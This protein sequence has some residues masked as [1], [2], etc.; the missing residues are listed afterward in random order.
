MTGV[1]LI[2]RAGELTRHARPAPS[3]WERLTTVVQRAAADVEHRRRSERR[4]QRAR[5]LAV[6]GVLLGAGAAIVL[7]RAAVNEGA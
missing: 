6:A 1:D 7:A 4:K 3:R 5:R 2:R